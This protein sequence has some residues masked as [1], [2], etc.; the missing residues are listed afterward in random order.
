M[1]NDEIKNIENSNGLIFYGLLIYIFIEA[2]RNF[3]IALLILMVAKLGIGSQYLLLCGEIVFYLSILLILLFIKKFPPIRTW[4]VI[5]MLILYLFPKTFFCNYSPDE[6]A[7]LNTYQF[8]DS[9][10]IRVIFSV[11]LIVLG[12][13]KYKIMRNRFV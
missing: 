3:L 5:L 1:R 8:S 7:I 10:I 9:V 4:F 6:L 2:G 12:F 11:I 13:V